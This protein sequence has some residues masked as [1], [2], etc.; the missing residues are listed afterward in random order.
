M[1]EKALAVIND[2][3]RRGIIE[4]Y[5]IGGGMASVAYGE[6]FLTYDLD[7]FVLL[8]QAATK[9]VT[10]EPIYEYLRAGG[11]REEREHIMI[12]AVPVQFIPAYNDLTVEAVN[13]AAETTHKGV[14]M[15]VFRLEHLVAV[16]LQTGRPKDQARMVQVLTQAQIDEAYL[17]QVLKRHRLGTRWTE[18]RKKFSGR[19]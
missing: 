8:P 15:H 17:R 16:M 2:L 12:G 9:I 11:F 13:E 5:A 3:E 4:K 19:K 6:P 7:V 1:I 14:K 18:F 10:L